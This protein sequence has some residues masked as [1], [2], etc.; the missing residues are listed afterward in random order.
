MRLRLPQIPGR[1]DHPAVACPPRWGIGAATAFVLVVSIVA[2]A[3]SYV[4]AREHVDTA[5][6]R[7]LEERAQQGTTTFESIGQQ[8]EAIVAAGGA[9]AEASDGD[10]D[11]FSEAMNPRVGSTLLSSVVLLRV[12]GPEVGQITQVG[13]REAMLLPGLDAGRLQRIREIADAGTLEVVELT[14][15]DG[16]RVIGFAAPA[17]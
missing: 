4:A 16:E 8:L 3:A 13:R 6:K 12:D 15:L 11:V 1:A 17:R 5:E 2:T 10:P 14:T 9:I 7:L